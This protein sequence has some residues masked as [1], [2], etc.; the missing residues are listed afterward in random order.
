MVEAFDRQ[1]Q[2]SSYL[3][4]MRQAMA[5][6][7]TTDLM[8]VAETLERAYLDG[9]TLYL[10]GNGGSAATASHLAVDLS[11]NTRVPGRPP[12]R[13]VSLVD[14][15]PAL[16]AWANDVGYDEVF[17]GQLA[18]LAEPGD[19]IIGISTSGNS[20]NV[21]QALRHGR[22]T[23]L[24]TVGLLGADGGSARELCDA[25]ALAP[26]ESIEEQEDIHMTFGHMLTRHMRAF[27]RADREPPAGVKA[28]PRQ[29]L[30]ALSPTCARTP[31]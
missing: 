6:V 20:P 24:T 18:G 2:F 9:R 11:K 15:V 16:T 19:V 25:Y 13:A 7:S 5:E 12:V 10:C 14:H 29:A 1:K 17:T 27:V 21:L 4:R 22:A 30:D 28:L 26:A 8:W 31:R 3:S 23:G